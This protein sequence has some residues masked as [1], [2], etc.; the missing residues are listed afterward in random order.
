MAHDSEYGVLIV[1]ASLSGHVPIPRKRRAFIVAFLW[2][3]TN[4][5]GGIANG[6]I[7]KELD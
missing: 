1:R 2:D 5:N 4:R 7:N 3:E 6:Y